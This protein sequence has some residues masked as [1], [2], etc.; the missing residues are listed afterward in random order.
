M[1]NESRITVQYEGTTV[2]DIDVTN[3]GYEELRYLAQ[4]G[5][6]AAVELD[7]R[8]VEEIVANKGAIGD[9][10]KESLESQRAAR[11]RGVEPVGH[12]ERVSRAVSE[13][14]SRGGSHQN[15]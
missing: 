15:E 10:V 4:I 13:Y 2:R 1:I 9:E 14:N 6:L 8:A 5:S 12:R 7:T 11:N 3:M